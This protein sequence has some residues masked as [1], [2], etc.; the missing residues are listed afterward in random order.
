MIATVLAVVG[1]LLGSIVTGTFQH[2]A[3]GRAERAA[4]AEQLRRDRLDAV[5]T[6]ASAGS[7]HRR[8]LWMRG[9][10]RL[11]GASDAELEE[12][13]A[14][15]HITRSAITRPLVALRLLVPDPAVHTTAQAMVVAT[16]DMVDAAT[17]IEELTAA[18]DTARAAHD[19]FI[20]AAA[21]YFGATT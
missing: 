18:Q 17:S 13:R 5:T 21:A 7:D 14:K 9:E 11:R 8:T 3:A 2:L 1:T 10:A 6:L 12:L 4:A 15:S 20:D 16:Y 19:R